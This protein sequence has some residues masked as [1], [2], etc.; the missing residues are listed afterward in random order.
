MYAI[1]QNGGKQ[2]KIEQNS[3]IRVPSLKVPVGEKVRLEEI[4]MLCEGEQVQVGRPFIEGAYAE[5]RVLR[6]GRARKIQI[7]K[8]KRRKN[9]HRRIGH[10]Q[11]F[12]ELLIDAIVAAKKKARP[13]KEKAAKPAEKPEAI[14]EIA[15]AE[16][17]A[18][19]EEKVISTVTEQ[20]L[21]TVKIE[22]AE[23]EKRARKKAAPKEKAA[24]PAGPEGETK[25]EAQ[26]QIKKRGK[27][28]AKA[29]PEAKVRPRTKAKA[30]TKGKESAVA[31]SVSEGKTKDKAEAK[32][33]PKAKPKAKTKT[34]VKAG[35]P[36]EK[37][38]ADK[39]A[40]TGKKKKE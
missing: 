6:H 9:Y 13:K 37:G 19:G 24:G 27:A 5:A 1:A 23:P 16:A 18:V 30:E 31:E 17:V 40:G 20:A 25:A 21:E 4:L 22:K 29:E 7:I 28:K 35:S 36:D 15:K 10:R 38:D 12:T 2:F 11:D 33:K 26:A 32:T 8:Y 34:K 39:G 3:V 14:H